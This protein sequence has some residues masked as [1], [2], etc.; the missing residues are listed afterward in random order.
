MTSIKMNQCPE[1]G[2]LHKV[3]FQCLSCEKLICASCIRICY[4]SDCYINLSK[5][6][7]VNIYFRDKYSHKVVV[8]Q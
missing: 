8:S 6:K 3:A 4:C 5:V 1:C 7:E 2:E